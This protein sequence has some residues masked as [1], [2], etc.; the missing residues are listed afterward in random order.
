MNSGQ[1]WTPRATNQAGRV[2]TTKTTCSVLKLTATN[3]DKTACTKRAVL[4]YTILVNQ[5][6]QNEPKQTPIMYADAATAPVDALFAQLRTVASGLTANEA[7]RRIAEQGLNE[8]R[9]RAITGWEIFV[10]QFRS[11]FIYLLAIAAGVAF[12]LGEPI[13]GAIIILFVLVNSLLGFIQEYQSEHSLRLLRN[14]WRQNVHCLRD[15]TPQFLDARN[16]VTGDVISLQAGDKIPADVR[17]LVTKN[18][19]ID[20][21]I[22][23]G[24]SVTVEKQCQSLVERPDREAGATNIGF[25]GTSLLSGEATAVVFATAN[26]TVVGG[27]SKLTVEL[28]RTSAFETGIK[29]LGTF[30]LRLVVV[31]LVLV[32]VMNLILKPHETSIGE[33]L[34]F[35]IALAVSV[36][37]EALPLVVTLSLS[38]GAVRLAKQHVVVKRLAAIEDLG[39]IDVLC[40]D[41]TGTITENHLNVAEVAAADRERCLFYG[42]LASSY[43]GEQTRETNNAFDIALW[44]SVAPAGRATLSGYRKLDEQPFDAVRRRNFIIVEHQNRRHLIVRGAIE[45][46]LP[47]CTNFDAEPPTYQSFANAE[48]LR[49]RRILAIATRQLADGE[50][51]IEERL[52]LLG[53][54]S[55]VDPLKADAIEAIQTAQR[56][57]V[58]IKILTG[59][60]PE[61]SGSVA[62]EV[63]LTDASSD[64]LT[65]A[66][67]AALPPDEQRA[68][69]ERTSVFARVSPE[70]KYHILQLLQA[71]HTVGFLGEGFNDAPALKS[72]HVALA[73]DRA[74]EVAKDASDVVLLNPGLM[75]IISGIEEGRRIFGNTVKYIKST[76]TSNFGNFYAIALVSLLIPYLPMLPIQLL[77]VNLLSDFPMIAVATDSVDDEELRRP[78]RYNVREIAL[79]ATFL[80]LVSTVFDFI[81]F[82][83]FQHSGEATLQTLWFVESILTELALIY[84]IRTRRNVLT[85]KRPS[86]QLLLITLLA[87]ILT[88]ALPFTEFGER[89]IHFIRPTIGQ[90]GLVLGIVI[91]Y[92]ITSEFVKLLYFRMTSR[93]DAQSNQA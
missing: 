74:S 32:F 52:H 4:R 70:D 61:V 11:A 86:R 78:R 76:L 2:P 25:S 24:E 12:L 22:L 13:D 71:N 85:A 54:V 89:F 93:R 34:L 66:A 21:S 41:K 51:P 69:V 64:V 83:F 48:G 56:L 90:L 44:D 59:D 60:A 43:V 31:T 38:G 45:S 20:E 82:A 28:E 27:I 73:V 26:N 72:A 53:L 79:I 7:A 81:F 68:A 30:I 23:T 5:R 80:G 75:T 14:Y 15:R 8:L 46:I 17:F 35:A 37:P 55:F 29:N 87:A 33:Q 6:D 39:S 84:S 88:I 9:S 58:T 49:G 57:G 40:T 92:F 3:N 77:F 42:V 18:L 36:I 91:A 62:R 16:L 65:G 19:T 10:R 1:C 63:G 47:L 50:T 67:F